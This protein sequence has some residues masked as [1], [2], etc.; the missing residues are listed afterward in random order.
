MRDDIVQLQRALAEVLTS[1]HMRPLAAYTPVSPPESRTSSEPPNPGPGGPEQRANPQLALRF[2]ETPSNGGTKI[3]DAQTQCSIPISRAQSNI[4]DDQDVDVDAARAW[5]V[6]ERSAMEHHSSHSPEQ[7]PHDLHARLPAYSVGHG[8]SLP[9]PQ[10][11]QQQQQQS[12]QSYHAAHAPQQSQSSPTHGQMGSGVLY[13]QSQA[14]SGIH[15]QHSGHQIYDAPYG[16][17][18]NFDFLP[19]HAQLPY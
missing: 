15:G 1:L 8:Q 16:H 12:W 9:H 10:Q 5:D 2:H 3:E 4:P 6:Q 19:P 18:G 13:A 14:Q 17:M 7:H 11:Q